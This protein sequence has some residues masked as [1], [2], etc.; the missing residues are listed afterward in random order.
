MSSD[1]VILAE[2][3]PWEPDCVGIA[4]Q[5]QSGRESA[6]FVSGFD[7]AMTEMVRLKVDPQVQR[8]VREGV[9]Q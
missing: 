5:W 4:L 9:L 7:E 2:I 1:R 8:I 6:Y 3:I